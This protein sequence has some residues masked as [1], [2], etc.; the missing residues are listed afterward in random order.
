MQ[1]AEH[2]EGLLSTL[3]EVALHQLNIERIEVL[4]RACRQL[5]ILYLQNNLIQKFENLHQLKAKLPLNTFCSGRAGRAETRQWS[6]PHAP[7]SV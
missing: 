2:N 4:G 1:K 6:P 5:K 3:E 7:L